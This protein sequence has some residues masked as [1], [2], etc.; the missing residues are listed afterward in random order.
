MILLMP[1]Y[2]Q[3]TQY[4]LLM[5]YGQENCMQCNQATGV[6]YTTFTT[7][8]SRYRAWWDSMTQEQRNSLGSISIWKCPSRRS[9]IQLSTDIDAT[10]V[11]LNGNSIAPGPV[12]DYA[13]VILHIDAINNPTTPGTGWVAHYLSNNASH[14]NNNF[15]PFRVSCYNGGNIDTNTPRDPIS[16]WAD[17]TSNQILFGES[18]IPANRMNVCKS[19]NWWEQADCS[20][21]TSHGATRGF[22]RPVHPAYR[23]ARG[24][25][26]Y[27]GASNSQSPL[28]SYGFGSN[29]TS[30]CNFLIGDG[31][32]RA[33]NST[34]PMSTILV[35]LVNTRDGKAVSLP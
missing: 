26:D 2:E 18:H 20:A 34:V 35:P 4:D 22:V 31:A 16:Y 14:S 24:P 1:Y 29:H 11:L 30:V 10:S 19:A 5:Q 27:T 33:V 15:G 3:N 9:G 25:N 12:S 23:L 7:E 13:A 17:G 21:L 6:K 8:N 28:T 32:V